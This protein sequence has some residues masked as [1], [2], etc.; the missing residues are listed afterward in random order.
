MLDVYVRRVKTITTRE[1][2]H[3][4]TSVKMLSPGQSLAVT[5][6]GKPSFTVTRAGKRP[7]LSREDLDRRAVK[8]SRKVDVVQGLIE[9][10]RQAR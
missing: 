2:F 8:L 10:R 6:K 9:L 1:F 7:R 4:P 3:S 5:D